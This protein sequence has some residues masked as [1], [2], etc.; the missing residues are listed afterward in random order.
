MKTLLETLQ[1]GTKYLEGRG[2]SDARLNMEHLVAKVLGCKR[3]DLYL[4]FD[5]PMAEDELAP[6]RE[7]LRQRGE[8]VPLQHLLGEVEFFGRTFKSDAR[9]LIPRPETEELVGMLLTRFRAK[10]PASVVD[11]GCG[12]G[13]I[14]LSLAAE[15]LESEV[16]LVDI[17]RD[18]LALA[19]E[20]AEAIGLGSGRV[21]IVEGDLLSGLEGPFDLVVANL[22]YI[23]LEET[24]ALEAEVSHDPELALVGG[25][26]GTELI[27]RLIAD[28]SGKVASGGLVA[29]EISEGQDV[30][31]LAELSAA[32]L[33]GGECLKDL[34][35]TERF[36]LALR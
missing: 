15:W 19:R 20:N 26:R 5:R 33:R 9:A 16:T 24:G 7:L 23:A 3:L 2:V 18:A 25:P 34:T 17:S 27:I 22:P 10:P 13:V 29:L 21:E 32:G 14:G 28:L 6:L 12:S 8:R 11:V 35:D 30:E 4:E 36:L 31:L 1:G